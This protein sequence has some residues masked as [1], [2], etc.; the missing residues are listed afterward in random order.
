MLL[1]PD[2]ESDVLWRLGGGAADEAECLVPVP[3][4]E[5]RKFFGRRASLTGEDEQRDLGGPP[6]RHAALVRNRRRFASLPGAHLG[7]A[8]PLSRIADK[9]AA[10]KQA[11]A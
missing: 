5:R 9:Q 4:Q 7:T 2:D 1:E 6:R 3:G 8:P 11:D 10:T